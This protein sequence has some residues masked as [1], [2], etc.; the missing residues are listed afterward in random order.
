ME[1]IH[2][3]A[4]QQG[5]RRIVS[6]DAF[7]VFFELPQ[8]DPAT[9]A[10][11][12]WLAL[13]IAMRLGRPLRIDGAVPRR[14]LENARRLSAI[15]GMWRPDLFS[16][17]PV[18]ARDEIEVAPKARTCRA[19]MAFSGGIDST[20]ALLDLCASGGLRPDL[21]TVHGMDYRR[22]DRDR[23]DRLLARTEP[24]RAACAGELLVA[25]S[26]AASVMRR[27]GI[28]PEV[29]FSF[30]LA[31]TCFLMENRYDTAHVA[32]DFADFQEVMV[33]P[34]STASAV[35]R[36]FRH[37]GM[38]FHLLGLDKTRSEKVAQIAADPRAL[39]SLSFCKDY[40]TRPE[41][42]GLCSKCVR[43]KAMFH[44]ALGEVPDIFLSRDFH[45]RDLERL[46]LSRRF[47]QI[48]AR[49]ILSLARR[50][51]REAEFAALAA[52]LEAPAPVQGA[53]YYLYKLKIMRD[54]R[55]ARRARA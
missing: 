48:F 9:D 7:E 30:Q 35:A 4:R 34:Y 5:D 6:S 32:A 16:E 55:R 1:S 22:D 3:T 27:F 42:C 2:V 18:T 23:F 24:F 49:D 54:A 25:R 20:S 41:N 40:A 28:A 19:I 47:E 13:P 11:A 8:A 37:E 36:L 39:R 43:S 51:G 52:R 53:K 17:V 33:G 46:D 44:A 29:G 12:L 14:A 45:P 38:G 26:D 15:W 10:F 50:A 31:A 21:V